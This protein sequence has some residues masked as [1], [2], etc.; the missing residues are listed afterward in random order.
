MAGLG[1]E[2]NNGGAR[3]ATDDGNVLVGGVGAL[4]LGNKAGGADDIEGGDAEEALGVVDT[5][6]FEDFGADGDSRVDLRTC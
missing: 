4:V 6:G 2:G 5:L 3:V 1:K